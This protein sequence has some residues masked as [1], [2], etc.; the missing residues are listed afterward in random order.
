MKF[1]LGKREEKSEEELKQD[2][3][4][5]KYNPKEDTYFPRLKRKIG[6]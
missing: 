1:A 4:E 2:L 3:K 5:K 6:H